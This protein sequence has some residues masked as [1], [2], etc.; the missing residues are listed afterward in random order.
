MEKSKLVLLT[1]VVALILVIVSSLAPLNEE[2]HYSD[3]VWP[4]HTN[5]QAEVKL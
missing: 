5:I 3:E 2:K 1:G 4:R